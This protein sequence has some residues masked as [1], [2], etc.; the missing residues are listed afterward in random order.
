MLHGNVE[1]ENR[2]IK[3]QQYIKKSKKEEVRNYGFQNC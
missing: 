1:L 3:W 2:Y